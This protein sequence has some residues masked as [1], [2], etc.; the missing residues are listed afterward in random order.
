MLPLWIS[1]ATLS[2]AQ[3]CRA[4]ENVDQGNPGDRQD[5]DT[6]CQSYNDCGQTGLGYWN[7]LQTTL[8]QT[9]PVDRTDGLAKFLPAYIVQ[10]SQLIYSN[11]NI[12]QD[13]TTHGFNAKEIQAW[14]TISIDPETHQ[15]EEYGAYDNSFDTKNGLIIANANYR[16]LDSQKTLPWSEIIYQTWKKIQA[17]TPGRSISNLRTVVRRQVVNT[18][19]VNVLAA[20]YKA[21]GLSPKAGDSTWYKWTEADSPYFFFALVGTDNVKGVI[22]LLNDHAAEIGK[23]EITEIWTRWPNLSPDIWI[24]IDAAPT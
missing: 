18:G 1:V 16:S 22:W 7:T 8:M 6:F 4:V 13:L 5:D 15:A 9:S 19:T 10:P 17:Q 11:E 2:L 3:Y 23:K 20:L 14:E 24:I 12:Q 21:R